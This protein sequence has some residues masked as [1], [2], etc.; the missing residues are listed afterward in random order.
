MRKS[1]AALIACATFAVANVAAQPQIPTDGGDSKVLEIRPTQ[2]PPVI[3][4]RLDD[5][6][7][8]GAATIDDLHQVQPV[9]YATPTERTIVYVTYDS[10]TLYVAAKL[11][12]REPDKII[13]RVLRQNQP[14]GPD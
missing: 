9:E 12:D 4:G 1:A 13:A 10:D 5:T 14:I 8:A 11:Y 3:D 2:T 6:A 7:W